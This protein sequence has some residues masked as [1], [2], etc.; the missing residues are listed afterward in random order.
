MSINNIPNM[1]PYSCLPPFK[2]WCATNF[3]F[4]EANF[5]SLTNYELLCKVTQYLNEVI[6]NE[7]AVESNVEA[8]YNAFVGLE[9]Y[10]NNYFD[11][12]DV[13]D[14]VNNKID[15]MVA[16]GY[17]ESIIS[18]YLTQPTKLHFVKC[19]TSNAGNCTVIETPTKNIIIDLSND[20]TGSYLINYLTAN[21]LRQI[22]YVCLTHYDNDHIGGPSAQG[23]NALL[24]AP[25]L[26]FTNCQFILPHKDI[27]FSL[28]QG[29]FTALENTIGLVKQI[30]EAHQIEY[31]EPNDKDSINVD[32]ANTLKFY[33][34][35][36]SYYEHYYDILVDD[37]TNYNNF[38]MIIELNTKDKTSIFPG[39]IDVEAQ[40]MNTTNITLCDVYLMEHHAVNTTIDY[41]FINKINPRVA[42]L[43]NTI[44]TSSAPYGR[45]TFNIMLYR[46]KVYTSNE[47]G[48]IIV[49]LDNIVNVSSENGIYNQSKNNQYIDI[50]NHFDNNKFYLSWSRL[51][52]LTGDL[53]NYTSAG[54]YF[55]N[56]SS[57]GSISN[58]IGESANGKLIV[59]ELTSWTRIQQV[60]YVNMP[61]PTIYTRLFNGTTWTP[62]QQVAYIHRGLI[63]ATNNAV[64]SSE[65]AQNFVKIPLTKT[66]NSYGNGLSIDSENNNIVIGDNVTKVR[67]SAQL[68]NEGLA[69]VNDRC[70]LAIYQNNAI[71]NRIDNAINGQIFTMTSSPIILNVA[72]GDTI[73]LQARNL[74]S[75]K[76]SFPASTYGTYLEVEVVE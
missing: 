76:L 30:L 74:T 70:M 45:P 16:N 5:D 48:N 39:D 49:T 69:S 20:T 53:N 60:Y 22:D 26:T 33:N 11:T 50:Y 42:I 29:D 13:Q 51:S 35:G 32:S 54:C 43:M 25:A 61:T 55:V 63:R 41:P 23:L 44:D 52:I 4:I 9:N 71:V 67:V 8:L 12:L 15:E 36:S 58:N 73:N 56:P 65:Q 31:I 38:S 21:N 66:L 75:G 59:M 10:V 27:D 34:I 6:S 28:M 14:E 68:V 47:S 37:K 7:N 1:K 64:F 46:S 18:T 57:A 62:W 19:G 24:N 17:F 72:K 40:E 2:L 3:P